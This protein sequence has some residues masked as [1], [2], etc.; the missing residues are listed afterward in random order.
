METRHLGDVKIL[1]IFGLFFFFFL[2]E[3]GVQGAVP[4]PRFFSPL[5]PVDG[6]ESQ[7][8]PARALYLR[9]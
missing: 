8:R 2:E 4:A 5:V 1:A 6:A 9:H 7:V 3:M